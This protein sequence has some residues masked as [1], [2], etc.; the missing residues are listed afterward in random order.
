MQRVLGI[1]VVAALL[2]LPQTALASDT[3]QAAPS[4]PPPVTTQ[5]PAAPAS[6]TAVA[7]TPAASST[8]VSSTAPAETSTS[9]EPSTTTTT[10]TPPETTATTTTTTTTTPPATT[11][12]TPTPVATTT[13]MPN[14]DIPTNDPC[15]DD[16]AACD[17]L[18]VAGEGVGPGVAAP[19][20]GAGRALPFTGIEDWVLPILMG[21]VALLGGV[22]AYRYASVREGLGRAMRAA[23]ERKARRRVTGYT[24]ALDNMDANARTAAFLRGQ[25][26]SAA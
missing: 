19:V 1:G 3:T 12:T 20:V 25:G 21:L 17:D 15:I 13:G 8:A 26:I 18:P 22:T 5:A 10:T 9:A 11:T 2:V 23:Q 14:V 4:T 16:I 7:S 24:Y 6:S